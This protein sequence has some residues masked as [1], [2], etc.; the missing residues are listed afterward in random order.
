MG[1]ALS[2]TLADNFGYRKPTWLKH[3][4]KSFNSAYYKRYIND[5]FALFEK[6]KQTLRFLNYMNKRH[7]NIKFSLVT[8]KDNCFSFLDLKICREKD[9]FTTSVSRKNKLSFVY[10]NFSS[11]VALEYKFGLVYTLLN[12]S[13]SS[14]LCLIFPNFILKLKHFR[15]S[16]TKML[17]LQNLLTNV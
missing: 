6:P 2:P 4:P 15:K 5:I 11:F 8:E 14:Q 16:F 1:S 9:K 7:K 3:C 17:I 13:K 10:T 12:R